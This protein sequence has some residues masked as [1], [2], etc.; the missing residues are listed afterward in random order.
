MKQKFAKYKRKKPRDLMR[1]PHRCNSTCEVY[2]IE[3]AYNRQN[4]WDLRCQHSH[5]HIRWMSNDEAGHIW[6]MVK[7]KTMLT[8]NG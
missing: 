8:K 2:L 4:K 5:R 7:H 6:D 1:Q 3:R